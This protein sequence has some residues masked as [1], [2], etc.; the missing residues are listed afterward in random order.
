MN[1]KQR[2]LKKN[3]VIT[4]EISGFSA[5]GSGVGHYNG[6]AVF[7]Q[8]AAAGDTVECV[9]IKDKP[10]YAVGKILNI[11][12]A[13]PD[14]VNS[15]CPVFPRCGGCVFRHISYEAEKKLKTQRV[16]DAFRRLG[17]IDVE[18]EPIITAEPD[19]YRNKAQYPVEDE[20]GRLKA[21]FYAPFSHRVIDCRA[22]RLQ[23]QE[24][25]GIL[26][27]FSRWAEKY[28]IPVYNEDTKKGL[29]R[30]IYIRK[31]FGTGEIMVCAVIN[32]EKLFKSNEL[33]AALIAE[34][35]KIKSIIVNINK[36]DTNVIL[37]SRCVTL[38]GSDTIRDM[39]CGKTFELSPLSFYQVNHDCAELLYGKAA[40]YAGKGNVLL[41][42]YCGA[43]TIG[44]SMS[45]N[46][47]EI[48]GV[49][50]IPEAVE[51]AKNNAKL[52]NVEN[53]RF[54]CADA[55]EAAK[56]L[57]KEGI[58][59]DVTVLDPPRKGCDEALLNAVASMKPEKIVYVSCD[60]A[61]LARDCA[62]LRELGYGIEKAAPADMFPRTA[63]VE[64]VTL[65]TR[66][67]E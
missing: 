15:D 39:L 20:N 30:H 43:G 33:C 45:D 19:N 37:G 28:K 50:I 7:V 65:I 59:P 54:I 4:L 47:K 27:T 44:I 51:N 32:G 24:F 29:L 31:G 18:L 36:E 16:S 58:H 46:F 61:T 62:K 3:D 55:S 48:I 12:K 41:D 23:P 64:C 63:H 21:G 26:R 66:A 42:M 5:E 49:E 2:A 56:M 8:G 17:H 9:I 10:N 14:R 52:N 22:C 6:M 11:K 67:K 13:S 35:E 38:Y 53:T 60:P 34:N 57:E 40:E 1:T 25:A